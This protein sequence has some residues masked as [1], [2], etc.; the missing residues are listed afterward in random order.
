[1]LTLRKKI[2][3]GLG[4]MGISISYFTVSFFFLYYLTNILQLPAALAGLAYFIGQAWDSL[5]DVFIGELNDRTRSRFGRKRMYLLFGALPFAL[6][7]MLLWL[8]PLNASQAVKFVYAT[9]SLVVYTT[10]YSLVTV[11]YMSL[12][13]VMTRDYDERTQITGIRAM[14]STLGTILGGGAA[15]LVSRFPSELVGL[16]VMA[17]GFGVLAAVAI[18][19][20]AQSVRG[21]EFP[22]RGLESPGSG[23]DGASQ[24]GP[25]KAPGGF[26]LYWKLLQDRNVAILMLFKLLG[27]VATGALMASLPYFARYILGDEGYSTFGLLAYILCTAAFVPIWNRLSRSHDKRKL[28]LIGMTAA[29]LVLLGIGLFVQASTTILFYVGCGLLGVAMSAYVLIPYSLVPDLVDYYEYQQGERHEAV[30]FGLW[31]TTHQMGIAAAGL[32]LG[33]FLQVFGYN[34]SLDVQTPAALTAV[35]LGLGI[36]PGVFILLAAL[37]L[38]RYAITRGVYQQIQAAL[39][40][41]A[42]VVTGPAVTGYR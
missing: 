10:I 24:E 13:P 34:G 37:A 26:R 29:A 2:G 6:S 35:R 25:R 30:F 38:Q 40:R 1:M 41:A 5:N 20:A 4:D 31:M 36:I 9:L 8:A 22:V 12:V 21:L 19:V 39:G 32:L 15:M 16:R 42:P 28:L 3:Y 7:F 14:L 23:L 11:P 33:G 27:A 17:G 18:F